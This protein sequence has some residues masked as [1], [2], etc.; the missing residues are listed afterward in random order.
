M[1]KRIHTHTTQI[2]LFFFF[3]IL[4]TVE[5]D[6]I[7]VCVFL[8]NWTKVYVYQCDSPPTIRCVFGNKFLACIRARAWPEWNRS[9]IPSAYTRT[10]RRAAQK[11]NKLI[12][13]L[14]SP[15]S[16]SYTWLFL[17]PGVPRRAWAKVT[18]SCG[19]SEVLPDCLAKM[20]GSL[21]ACEIL[22]V[23]MHHNKMTGIK[24]NKAHV[25]IHGVLWNRTD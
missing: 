19:V 17:S 7:D 23:M 4:D 6:D 20:A 21:R 16:L 3:Q 1:Q 2:K 9:K 22:A 10:G 18:F 12:C 11:Q 25:R 14:D 5:G 8:K 15:N 24:S 13:Y